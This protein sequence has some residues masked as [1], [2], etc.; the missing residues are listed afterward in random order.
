MELEGWGGLDY[1]IRFGL[2]VTSCRRLVNMAGRLPA[3]DP[4][5]HLHDRRSTMA[6]SQSWT[7]PEGPSADGGLMAGKKD[8]SEHRPLFVILTFRNPFPLRR[9]I[10]TVRCHWEWWAEPGVGWQTAAC[11]RPPDL[12]STACTRPL[13][14]WTSRKLHRP[15][16]SKCSDLIN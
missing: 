15:I 3:M 6:P 9:W 12:S 5:R 1:I 7:R 14:A 13:S 4:D 10:Y 16:S 8:P 2:V 11:Q